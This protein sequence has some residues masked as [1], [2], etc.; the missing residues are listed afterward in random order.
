MFSP[1]VL[2]AVRSSVAIP[3]PVPFSALKR[4][5]IAAAHA[6]LLDTKPEL[7][8][9]FLLGVA[10]GLRRKEVDLLEWSSFQWEKNE[11][12][13]KATAHFAAKS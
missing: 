6:E 13:I 10:G 4:I 7:Y 5:E 11:I 9:V 12:E 8:R 3:D 2:D 1:A